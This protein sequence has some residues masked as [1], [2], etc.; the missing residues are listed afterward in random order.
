MDRKQNDIR[1]ACFQQHA[2]DHDDLKEEFKKKIIN[3][4]CAYTTYQ[5]SNAKNTDIVYEQIKHYTLEL[6]IKQN[7]LKV[8]KQS[9]KNSKCIKAQ[10]IRGGMHSIS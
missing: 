3:M 6:L 5:S 10:I 4:I 7:P 2:V 9:S 8:Y 1:F